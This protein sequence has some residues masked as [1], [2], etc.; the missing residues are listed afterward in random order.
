MVKRCFLEA[1]RYCLFYI[2]KL[3]FQI[4]IFRDQFMNHPMDLEGNRLSYEAALYY[5]KKKSLEGNTSGYEAIKNCCSKVSE[6]A[7][8]M[9]HIFIWL[10]VL[11]TDI[12]VISN[13]SIILIPNNYNN[14]TMISYQTTTVDLYFNL[15]ITALIIYLSFLFIQTITKFCLKKSRTT[16]QKSISR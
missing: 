7:L 2:E 16:I 15:M 10:Y 9:S 3:I 8:T 11:V 13:F 4:S 12:M 14:V 1:I 6:A 5:M